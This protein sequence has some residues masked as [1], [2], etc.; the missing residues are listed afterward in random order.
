MGRHI[1][2]P[3]SSSHLQPQLGCYLQSREVIRG[4][5]GDGRLHVQHVVVPKEVPQLLLVLVY[6]LNHPGKRRGAW[7]S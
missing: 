2:P 7:A 5:G 6:H 4:P 3:V 1:V